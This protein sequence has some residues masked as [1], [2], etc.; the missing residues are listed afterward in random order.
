MSYGRDNGERKKNEG[1]REEGGGKKK[2]RRSGGTKIYSRFLR[3][4]LIS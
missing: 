3:N 2:K 1:G 4:D